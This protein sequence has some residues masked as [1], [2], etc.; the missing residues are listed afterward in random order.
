MAAARARGEMRQGRQE[1]QELRER[2]ASRKKTQ[3]GA[4]LVL[5]ARR[6]HT[7]EIVPQIV[8]KLYRKPPQKKQFIFGGFRYYF[9]IIC[10]TGNSTR[11]STKIIL[12][13]N[14]P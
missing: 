1:R 11:N 5:V 10:G 4:R 3:T 12:Q 7:E 2:Q 14:G 9:G 13:Q 8:P 6:E